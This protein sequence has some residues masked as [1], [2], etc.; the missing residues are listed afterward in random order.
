MIK[1]I[2][3]ITYIISHLSPPGANELKSSLF[4]NGLH[5]FGTKSWL[6]FC[7]QTFKEQNLGYT[8]EM[9]LK[10][11]S[12]LWIKNAIFFSS[13]IFNVSPDFSEWYEACT[14]FFVTC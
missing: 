4:G 2:L 13:E 3:K 1:I 10:F 7:Q 9:N 12:V 11:F 6:T 8:K 14:L 5:L